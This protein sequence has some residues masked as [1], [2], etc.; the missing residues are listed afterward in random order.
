MLTRS[1]G[2]RSRLG[3]NQWA[4]GRMSRRWLG[5]GTNWTAVGEPSYR[6]VFI[7]FGSKIADKDSIEKYN[8]YRRSDRW[9]AKPP[10]D[11]QFN[12]KGREVGEERSVKRSR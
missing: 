4:L 2:K 3:L 10:P 9:S 1:T 6:E 5:E 7:Y 12:L 8:I 11:A